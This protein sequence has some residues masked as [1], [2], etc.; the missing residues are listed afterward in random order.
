MIVNETSSE[1]A[2]FGSKMLIGELENKI[3]QGDCL[4]WMKKIP[5]QTFDMVCTVPP[6]FLDGSYFLDGLGADWKKEKIDEKIDE[7][8]MFFCGWQ[9]T[10][11]YEI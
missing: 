2:D 7:K 6:Y 9:F 11:R 1:P 10:Q 8:R 3:L 5:D 4:E